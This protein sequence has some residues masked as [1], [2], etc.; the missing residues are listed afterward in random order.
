MMKQNN[1]F[2]LLS[3]V[4]G[5]SPKVTKFE[6]R[7]EPVLADLLRSDAVGELENL[8]PGITPAETKPVKLTRAE[9]PLTFNVVALAR[10]VAE[11]TTTISQMEFG[12]AE[13]QDAGGDGD[14]DDGGGEYE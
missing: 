4:E 1:L 12:E 6:I 2:Q 5:S 7:R 13:E 3:A 10:N 14:E 9:Q 11:E 8:P